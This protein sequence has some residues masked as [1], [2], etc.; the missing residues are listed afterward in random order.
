[1]VPWSKL[2]EDL[3]KAILAMIIVF[4]GTSASCRLG[5]PICDPPPPPAT[6]PMICDPPP[7]PSTTPKATATPT[8]TATPSASPTPTPMICDPPP[9]PPL[10][11]VAPGQRFTVRSVQIVPDEGL[12]GVAI[13][14]TIM[15]QFSQPLAGLTISIEQDGRQVQVV[16]DPMGRFAYGAPEGGTYVLAVQGDETSRLNVELKPHDVATIVWVES[17]EGSQSPLPLAEIRAVDIVWQDGLPGAAGLSFAAETAW[18]GARYRWSVSGGTLIEAGEGVM[19][20]PPLEPGRYLLQVVADW[21]R[22]GLAVDALVL[23]V[24]DDGSVILS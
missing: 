12:A 23:I 1:M 4:G 14:G 10:V 8:P 13:H 20:Q 5:P 22:T 2:P 6:T 19:W 11:T 7:P 21:G 24:E 16:S 3:Q 9:P 15:D 17:W 18:P